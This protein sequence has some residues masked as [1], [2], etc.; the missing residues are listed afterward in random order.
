MR[1]GEVLFGRETAPNSPLVLAGSVY[2]AE[3]ESAVVV[4]GLGIARNM[5][6]EQAMKGFGARGF[7]HWLLKGA[8]SL[9]KKHIPT[10]AFL[11]DP[12]DPRSRT[13]DSRSFLDLTYDGKFRGTGVFFRTAY[14]HYA[15]N[16]TYGICR[17]LTG[18][19]TS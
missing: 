2:A 19:P 8:Y 6:D 17:N 3:G 13:R 7:G 9:R 5:D 10:G 4:P 1:G 18:T 16:G 15:Y 11:T 12:A 14:D